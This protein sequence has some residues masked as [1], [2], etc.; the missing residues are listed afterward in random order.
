LTIPELA[1]ETGTI[2][3]LHDAE[4]MSLILLKTTGVLF[5]F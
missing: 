4:P 5:K 2:E 3:V 1:L